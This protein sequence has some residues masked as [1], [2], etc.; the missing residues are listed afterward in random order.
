MTSK[1]K[2]AYLTVWDCLTEIWASIYGW[3]TGTWIFL[4]MEKN[5]WAF[6]SFVALIPYAVATSIYHDLVTYK[7]GVG[8]W[9]FFWSIIFV[10][11]VYAWGRFDERHRWANKKP[12][13]TNPTIFYQA[14]RPTYLKAEPGDIWVNPSAFN[15]VTKVY[16]PTGWVQVP[17]TYA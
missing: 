17:V 11:S 13:K 2:P 3:V 16:T 10:I 12:V 8:L 14:L 1:H 9:P 15:N 7:P 6:Y 5:R 4:N